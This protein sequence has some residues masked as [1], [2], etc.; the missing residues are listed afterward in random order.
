MPPNVT[1]CTTCDVFGLKTHFWLKF[2][3]ILVV[4]L[5]W[6]ATQLL[7]TQPASMCRVIPS[8]IQNSVLSTE[9]YQVSVNPVLK[10]LK[11]S[12]E[13]SFTV[14]YVGHSDLVSFTDFLSMHFSSLSRSLAKTLNK[15]GPNIVS[16]STLLDIY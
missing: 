15:T 4:I 13:C 8:Q 11:D 2:N 14:R 3:L 1:R 9:F 16:W 12:L 6:A 10:F 5:I 7:A